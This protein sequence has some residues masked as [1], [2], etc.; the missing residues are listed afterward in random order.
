MYR[1][2]VLLT[3]LSIF[4]HNRLSFANHLIMI[5]NKVYK[6]VGLLRKPH[7]ILPRPALLTICK[8]FLRPHLDYSDI[9]YEQAYNTSSQQVLK[10]AK[11]REVS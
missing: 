9:I 3:D 10:P 5:L 1:K 11:V 7:N 4:L 8:S 2:L 6:T